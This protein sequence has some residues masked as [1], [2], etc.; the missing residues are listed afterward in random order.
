[1]KKSKAV[2]TIF[3]AP[4]VLCYL[5][6][7][8]YPTV[9]TVIMSFFRVEGVTEPISNWIFNGVN[10]YIE[11]FQSELFVCSLINILKIWSIGGLVVMV[12]ALVFAVILTSGVRL[13]KFFRSVIYLPN[14]I[15]A[16]AMGTMWLEYA[17]SAE[18]GLINRILGVFGIAPVQWTGPDMLFASMLIAYCFGMIGRHM[19]IFMDGIE[20]IPVDY[21]EAAT[22]EG[23][24]VFQRFGHITLPL[25][26]GVLH[27]TLVMWTVSAVNF[28]IWSQIFSPVSVSRSTI[29]PVGYMYELVFGSSAGAG[30][31]RNSGG[32][33]AI[34]VMLTGIVIVIFSITNLLSKRDDVEF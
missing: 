26:K 33:A 5:I 27:T 16:V 32:G 11:L 18:F 24:N 8:M 12:M 4:A 9:R 29:A 28:F 20:R 13:K 17:Y 30:T 14:V 10:N 15:S 21:F 3:L 34:G 19:L 22:L 31:A 7:F 2:L 1:M 6:V 25:L 23:A